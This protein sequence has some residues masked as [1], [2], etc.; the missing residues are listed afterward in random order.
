MSDGINKFVVKILVLKK[1]LG[2]TEVL[3]TNLILQFKL[4]KNKKRNRLKRLFIIGKVLAIAYIASC[5]LLFIL[6]TRFIFQPTAIIQKI[7]DAFNITYEE[8]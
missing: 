4:M 3:T 2:R 7:P 1:Y 6:Q 5:I 8:V